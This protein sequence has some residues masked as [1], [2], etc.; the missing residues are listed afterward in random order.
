[1][2]HVA[3]AIFSFAAA[4]LVGCSTNNDAAMRKAIRNDISDYMEAYEKSPESKPCVFSE[5]AAEEFFKTIPEIRQQTT[6]ENLGYQLKSSDNVTMI[7]HQ[8]ARSGKAK[9]TVKNEKTKEESGWLLNGDK[10]YSFKGNAYTEITD[11]KLRNFLRMTYDMNMDFNKI[12]RSV[13]ISMFDSFKYDMD[14]KTQTPI[15][16]PIETV[17]DDVRCY[18]ITMQLATRC[19]AAEMICYVSSEDH[20]IIRTELKPLSGLP[21]NDVTLSQMSNF[22]H[23]QSGFLFA[24]QNVITVGK[25]PAQTYTKRN[26]VLKGLDAKMFEPVLPLVKP[27]AIP[28]AKPAAT[29]APAK[30]AAKP[31]A[32]PAPA[33]PA[34]ATK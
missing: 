34:P 9:I 27:A 10:A 21:S 18:K 3:I 22:V 29:T 33:K 4:A 12:V 5:K 26:I 28:A 17:K 2:K 13:Q 20:N 24:T 25:K 6:L 30:T 14:K 23:T 8:F 15:R 11:A 32:K 31:A 7:Q 19:Y 1:M 16:E